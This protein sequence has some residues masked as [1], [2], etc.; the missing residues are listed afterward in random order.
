VNDKSFR[1]RIVGDIL[2][3][4]ADQA[5]IYRYDDKSGFGGCQI[6]FYKFNAVFK[7]HGNLLAFGQS[8]RKQTVSQLIDPLVGFRVG[9]FARTVLERHGVR[10]LFSINFKVLS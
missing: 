8:Q 1:I 6:H 5:K 2:N 9:K 7:Q 4:R 3:F 10:K